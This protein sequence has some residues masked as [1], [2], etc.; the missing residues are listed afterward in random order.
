MF[1]GSLKI[2]TK[3]DI[4]VSLTLIRDLS[5]NMIEFRKC[6]FIEVIVKDVNFPT[7]LTSPNL[8]F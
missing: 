8:E 2:L 6:S 5:L 4:F 7:R 3:L 1:E